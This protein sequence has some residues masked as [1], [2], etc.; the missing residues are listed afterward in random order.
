MHYNQL[1]KF[2][3]RKFDYEISD[4]EEDEDEDG[5]DAPVIVDM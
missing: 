5:E 1:K 4:T 3:I 2:I